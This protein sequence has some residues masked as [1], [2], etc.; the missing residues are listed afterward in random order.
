MKPEPETA[1]ATKRGSY[2]WQIAVAA[3]LCVALVVL[4][5]LPGFLAAWFSRVRPTG[6]G[7]LTRAGPYSIN[8]EARW[9]MDPG[10]LDSPPS[11]PYRNYLLLPSGWA[12]S[13]SP[14]VRRFY[15]WEYHL[16]GGMDAAMAPFQ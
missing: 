16:A 10:W 4:L 12:M 14:A 9:D 15:S 1:D 11:Q 7:Y 5:V 3:V 8:G 6:G 2:A 13:H